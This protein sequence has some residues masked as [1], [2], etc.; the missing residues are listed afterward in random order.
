M[1]WSQGL[2]DAVAAESPSLTRSAGLINAAFE[3][4]G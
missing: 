2:S 4:Q 3:Y 1:F